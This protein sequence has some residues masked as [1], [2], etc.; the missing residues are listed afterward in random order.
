MLSA[1]Q[2][3][4][5]CEFLAN[6]VSAQTA[7]VLGIQ[8]EQVPRD[9]PLG[10]LGL[11]SLMAFELSATL[12]TKLGRR[13]PITI[14]QGNRT[15]DEVADRISRVFAGNGE[16]PS[17]RQSASSQSVVAAAG[18]AADVRLRFLAPRSLADPDM[19]FEAAALTYIPEDFITRGNL[20]TTELRAAFG[21][22]PFLSCVIDGPIGRVGAFMLPVRGRDLFS[23]A[24]FVP[25]SLFIGRCSWR[26]F[27]D[28]GS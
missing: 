17:E 1:L 5:R 28:H 7:A 26:S 24:E 14:L 3:T 15:V 2:P 13:L 18:K 10:N 8:T 16:M 20:G 25:A 9:R 4:P 6:L 23:G 19:R 21:A 22:E 11:D 12:E 27:R